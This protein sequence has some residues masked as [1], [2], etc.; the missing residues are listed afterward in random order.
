[1]TKK[2]P[3][4]CHLPKKPWYW[5]AWIPWTPHSWTKPCKDCLSDYLKDNNPDNLECD[6]EKIN[7]W[8]NYNKRV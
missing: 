7:N 8:C 6:E 1:M 2:R 5:P 4:G 3:E